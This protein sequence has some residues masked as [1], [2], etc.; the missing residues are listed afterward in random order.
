MTREI[1][2]Y[3]VKYPICIE[4]G[5]EA[6]LD[7]YIKIYIGTKEN[8]EYIRQHSDVKLEYAEEYAISVKNGTVMIEGND[9]NGALYGCVDFYDKYIVKLEYTDND[10]TYWEN[11]FEKSLPNFDCRQHPAVVSR[12]IWTWGHV[13]YDYRAFIDNM[14]RLKLNMI[15]VWTDHIPVNAADMIQYAHDA[16]IKFIW[17]YSWLWGINCDAVDLSAVNEATCS[18]LAKYERDYL[19]LGGDG[20]YFQSFTELDKEY[21]GNVLIAEAVTDFVNNT[22]RLFLDKYPQLEL[23]FGLHANSVKQR[24]EYIARV[25]KRV[26]IVWENCSSFPFDYIPKNVDTFDDTA[27]FVEKIARLRGC[28]ERFG[29]VT[30]GLTKLEW[31][32][33]DSPSGP[34]FDGVCSKRI[35]ENRVKRKNIIW[36]Y[37]QSYW[38]TNSTFAADIVRLMTEAKNGD[39]CIS[40]LVE[41]GMLEDTMM[42]PIALYS[43]MLWDPY[44]D[45]SKRINEVALRNYVEFA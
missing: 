10:E 38:F 15:T 39:L 14:V 3:T 29:A 1:L 43:E 31:S 8:N 34:I 20:I 41:D 44:Y 42:F 25:D 40:A 21:I 13:I 26:R 4:C 24:L 5:K 12:G 37:I 36:K 16:G 11:P 35:L 6:E 18:V 45:N 28:D 27:Q 23:Q 2:D 7:D 9:D 19:P 22:S 32:N 30:K 33:F 17:G